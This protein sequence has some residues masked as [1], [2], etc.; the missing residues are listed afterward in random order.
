MKSIY[1]ILILF[2]SINQ[3]ALAQPCSSLRYQSGIFPEVNVYEDI[4][5]STAIPYSKK[6]NAKAT[7]YSFDFY[8]PLN[9]EATKRPLVLMFC[10]GDFQNG[11]K[12]DSDIRTWCDSLASYGFTCAAINYRLGY[13]PEN[14]ESAERAIYRGVQD[15]KAA[16]RYFKE[17]HHTYKVDTN[18][19]YL[20]GDEAGAVAVLH[21]IF[22]TEEKQRARATYGIKDERQDLGCLNCSG[23]PYKHNTNVAGLINMR[24]KITSL[25]LINAR[26]KIPM[27]HI[28]DRSNDIITDENPLKDLNMKSVTAIHQKMDRLGY[29]TEMEDA[30]LFNSSGVTNSIEANS[31]WNAAWKQISTFLYNTMTFAS[32]TPKGREVACAGKPTTYSIED[33]PNG[34]YCWEVVGG[35]IIRDNGTS[36]EIAWDYDN[37]EGYIRVTATN[38]IGITGATS[39]PLTV[40]LRETAVSDF[41]FQKLDDNV[42][43]FKDESSYGTFFMIDFGDGS[44]PRSGK[45]GSTLIHTFD[46]KGDYTISQILENSCGTA[47]S[48]QSMSIK[49]I[50][51]DSWVE[52][53]KAIVLSSDVFN[54]GTAV[55]IGLSNDLFYSEVRIVINHSDE[56]KIF[57]KTVNLNKEKSIKLT[58]SDLKRGKYTIAINADGNTVKKYFTI[59]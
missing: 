16:I 9:D 29:E 8:E 37:D 53:K 35:R 49:K 21:A 42:I 22:M 30:S 19:I 11:D 13:N 31:I 26:K 52:L 32:P 38:E 51:I 45:P 1:S 48:T 12:K 27:I 50:T 39:I 44:S 10:G 3:L 5:Y 23:N 58:A 6:N 18:H 7:E 25:D 40:K 55:E 15:A 43:E 14:K 47:V 20:G 2:I 28:E 34:K 57:D 24:G 59:E 17:F 46:L 54:Y 56:Q 36:V 33:I 41:S 4:A